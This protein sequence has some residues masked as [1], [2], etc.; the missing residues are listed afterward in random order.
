VKQPLPQDRNQ[1]S[2]QYV[3]RPAGH[4]ADR[5]VASLAVDGR[6]P[7]IAV[8]QIGAAPAGFRVAHERLLKKRHYTNAERKLQE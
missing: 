4:W 5:R 1:L 2:Y 6:W 3:N 7:S 8:A